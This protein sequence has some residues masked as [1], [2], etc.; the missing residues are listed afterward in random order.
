MLRLDPR[1]NASPDQV[2]VVRFDG[3]PTV[4]WPG[5]ILEYHDSF[6]LAADMLVIA[7]KTIR[8]PDREKAFDVST[9]YGRFL[10]APDRTIRKISPQIISAVIPKKI[11]SDANTERVSTAADVITRVRTPGK[12]RVQKS[13]LTLHADLSGIVEFVVYLNRTGGTTWPRVSD[14]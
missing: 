10:L 4:R 8:I 1:D 6:Q 14:L 3:K 13:T 12:A 9:D 5:G 7:T 11:Q 2:R